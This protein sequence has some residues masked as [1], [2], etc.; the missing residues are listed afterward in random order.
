MRA[1]LRRWMILASLSLAVGAT[2]AFPLPTWGALTVPALALIPA[3]MAQVVAKLK[4]EALFQSAAPPDA[5][6]DVTAALEAWMSVVIMAGLWGVKG[7]FAAAAGYGAFAIIAWAM[8]PLGLAGLL[9]TRVLAG[10][11]KTV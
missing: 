8:L 7:A 9:L 10:R 4:L 3:G 5:L 11:K 2:M 6:D 1:S